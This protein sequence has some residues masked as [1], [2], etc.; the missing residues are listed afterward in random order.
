MQDKL[1]VPLSPTQVPPTFDETKHEELNLE[2][3]LLYVAL[4]RARFNIFMFEEPSDSKHEHPMLQLWKHLSVISTI[5]G[6]DADEFVR[7][8]VSKKRYSSNFIHSCSR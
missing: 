4:T 8:S 5:E 6:D 2:L 7:L 3:K 1:D